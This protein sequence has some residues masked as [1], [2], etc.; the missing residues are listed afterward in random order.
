VVAIF[1]AFR[2]LK[3]PNLGN[4]EA[5]VKE[6]QKDKKE[7]ALG[8]YASLTRAVYSLDDLLNRQ[9]EFFELSPSQ[10]RVLEHLLLFGPMA[11]GE[12]AGRIMFG[13]STI[14]V[15]TKNLESWG[16]VVRRAHETDGRKAIVDLS[17]EGR[18]LIEQILPKRAKILRAKMCVLGKR[19]EENLERLCRKLAQ[20]DAVAFMLE[21][22]AV[23]EDEGQEG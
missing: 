17:D 7:R 4:L 12:L 15:V 21:I 14:S 20:G 8:T 16:L 10:Y 5:Y 6:S 2:A 13:D 18:K 1:G 11:T 9:C 3:V 22:T 19:E 23:D